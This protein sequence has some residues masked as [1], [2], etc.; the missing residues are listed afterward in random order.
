MTVSDKERAY[1][2]KRAATE[3]KLADGATDAIVAALHRELYARYQ[4]LAAANDGHAIP[5]KLAIGSP[6]D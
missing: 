2:A 3:L 4:L 5:D 6:A 1:H